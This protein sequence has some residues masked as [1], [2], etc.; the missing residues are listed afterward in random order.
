MCI[1]ALNRAGEAYKRMQITGAKM[2]AL[3][4]LVAAEKA[5]EGC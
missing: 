3:N 2:A 1:E 5:A 4:L